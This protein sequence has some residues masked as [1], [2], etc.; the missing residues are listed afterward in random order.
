MPESEADD[1][2]HLIALFREW[3]E[4]S[5]IVL[6]E[7]CDE[8]AGDESDSEEHPQS[9]DSRQTGKA[10][11]WVPLIL[12]RSK[13][14]TILATVL[15]ASI[16]I[17][18]Y[19][20]S[21]PSI[22]S[23]VRDGEG[24]TQNV[25]IA[26]DGTVTGL[27]DLDS[28]LRTSVI[29]A[30]REQTIQVLVRLPLLPGM[31][32]SDVPP[33]SE[34]L[35]LEPYHTV[36]SSVQPVFRWKGTAMAKSYQV[37]V[38]NASKTLVEK[39]ETLTTSLWTPLNSLERGETY[40]WDVLVTFDDGTTSLP[41]NEPQAIFRILSDEEYADYQSMVAKWKGFHSV[42]GTFFVQ[43]GLLD[44]AQ[45]EFDELLQLNPESISIQSLVEKTR[46]IRE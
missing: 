35:V 13:S 45:G 11:T 10:V 21:R 20:L 23:H 39:S 46:A 19:F 44:E 28:T 18:F 14:F 41:R 3:H 25:A 37:H 17:G 29:I 6:V 15:V 16:G 24:G 34:S 31:K 1:I 7:L 12:R 32:G 30:L 38:Y 9:N 42:L 8:L 4:A 33:L 27:P 40:L 36:V 22:V 5:G 26:S 2:E 43:Q